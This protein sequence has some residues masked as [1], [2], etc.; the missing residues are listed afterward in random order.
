[1]S[2]LTAASLKTV[3][4]P[5]IME[6][7]CRNDETIIT[8]AIEAAV[9]ET[10]LY[11]SRYLLAPL[12]GNN[13]S[14]PDI[15]DPFLL[16]LVKNITAWRIVQLAAVTVDYD[17]YRMAYTDALTTL[18]DINRGK[19]VPDGWAY[20]TTPDTPDGDGIFWKSSLKRDNG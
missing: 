2:V 3:L 12:L 5:E 4:Y 1:M 10:K 13:A 11:L 15:P 19:L 17:K 18:K 20:A 6:E 7:I 16:Q 8:G 9:N 14:A